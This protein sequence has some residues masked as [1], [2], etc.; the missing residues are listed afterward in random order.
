MGSPEA[1]AEGARAR[2]RGA[3]DGL[4]ERLDSIVLRREHQDA[5]REEDLGHRRHKRNERR[6]RVDDMLAEAARKRADR[7]EDKRHAAEAE[8]GDL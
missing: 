6:G 3:R 2:G 1:Q 5:D 7:R 4:R 8:G